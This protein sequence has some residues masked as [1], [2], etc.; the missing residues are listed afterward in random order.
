[1]CIISKERIGFCTQGERMRG[2]VFTASPIASQSEC[3]CVPNEWIPTWRHSW[4]QRQRVCLKDESDRVRTNYETA[5]GGRY[6]TRLMVLAPGAESAA[7]GM[8]LTALTD[9]VHSDGAIPPRWKWF[10]LMDEEWWGSRAIL[11]KNWWQNLHA[12]SC[13]LKAQ[14][15][16]RATSLL[17]QITSIEVDQK[18][19]SPQSFRIQLTIL[20]NTILHV[21][22]EYAIR[23]IPWLSV[24]RPSRC[25]SFEHQQS[26]NN[27]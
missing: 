13:R 21:S 8:S 6:A 9:R 12:V 7:T 10:L 11:I 24:R 17:T 20:R 4:P 5:T 16:N 23:C 25:I 1:M 19:Q 22:N 18:I 3:K 14:E 26:I 27:F 2:E 15:C